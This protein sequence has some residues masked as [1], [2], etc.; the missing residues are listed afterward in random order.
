MFCMAFQLS[1]MMSALHLHNNIAKDY[2]CNQD[3]TVF[4][5]FY[6]TNLL[7]IESGMVL[8]LFQHIELL[9]SL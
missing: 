1:G 7:H 8:L 3:G 2:L 5:F 6:Q 4:S 9:I